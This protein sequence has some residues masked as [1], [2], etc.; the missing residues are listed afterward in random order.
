LFATS[1]EDI[2]IEPISGDDLI[3]LAKQSEEKQ[4][5]WRRKGEEL[6]SKSEMAIVL[7]A[8]GLGTRLEF[9]HPKGFYVLDTLPSKKSLFQLICEKIHRLEQNAK[10]SFP[11]SVKFFKNHDFNISFP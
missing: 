10:L 2:S 5:L 7:V 9:D 8:G 11:S 1:R 6:I 4:N 3:S